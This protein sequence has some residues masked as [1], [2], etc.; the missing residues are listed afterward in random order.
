MPTLYFYF[1]IQFFIVTCRLCV[2]YVREGN[3]YNIYILITQLVWTTWTPLSSVPKKLLN[4][5]THS[6]LG[7]KAEY[8][9]ITGSIPLLL[10]LYSL[11]RYHLTGIGIPIIDLRWSDDHRRFIMGMLYKTDV[12]VNWGP[13]DLVM[14]GVMVLTMEDVFFSYNLLPKCWEIIKYRDVFIC[15]PE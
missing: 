1:L 2:I 7:G 12:F 13:G 9:E 10:G 15:F 14:Q 8:S 4:L 5:I 3:D 11:K 6:P